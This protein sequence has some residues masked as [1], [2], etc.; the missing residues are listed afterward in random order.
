[1]RNI[2]LELY[3]SRFD[4]ASE[5]SRMLVKIRISEPHLKPIDSGFLEVGIRILNFKKAT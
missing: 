3:F 5:L 2:Q 4:L 1:M